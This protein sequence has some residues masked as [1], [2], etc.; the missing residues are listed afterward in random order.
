LWTDDNPFFHLGLTYFRFGRSVD[1]STGIIR[2]EGGMKIL[3]T[4][5]GL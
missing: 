2:K 1:V 5:S 4:H 3:F